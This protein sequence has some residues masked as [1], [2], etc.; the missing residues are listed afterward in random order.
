[1]SGG[2]ALQM[3]RTLNPICF[4]VN[5]RFK[6]ITTSLLCVFRADI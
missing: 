3:S 4:L 1:M 5:I 2:Y 6:F